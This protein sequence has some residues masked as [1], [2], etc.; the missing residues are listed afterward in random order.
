MHPMQCTDQGIEELAARL[1][2]LYA[3]KY[4]H[5]AD[6]N[7]PYALDIHHLTQL[8]GGTITYTL[9]LEAGSM[10]TRITHPLHDP[11]PDAGATFAFTTTLSKT[12]PPRLQ[13]F[14]LAHEIGH[15]YLH[16]LKQPPEYRQAEFF[17]HPHNPAEAKRCTQANKFAGALLMPAHKF[18]QAWDETGGDLI[19]IAELF[20][21]TVVTAEAR[22]HHLTQ[23]QSNP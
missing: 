17:K 19:K 16:H 2:S 20:K 4:A 18:H 10:S 23:M 13:N 11:E 12:D 1:H 3:T 15:V 22:H 14:R 9:H 5:A 7:H 8:L 21:V 6:T